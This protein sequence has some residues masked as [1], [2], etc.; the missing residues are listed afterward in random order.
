MLQNQE[1]FPSSPRIYLRI[2]RLAVDWLTP[3]AFASLRLLGC[4][5]YA[6]MTCR[7]IKSYVRHEKMRY[8]YRSKTFI[9]D[10]N[11]GSYIS[12]DAYAK[13]FRENTERI[14][15][16]RLSPHCLRHTHTAMMAEAGVSLETISR[17]LGHADSKITKE[18]YMHVTEKMKDRDREMIRNVRII[19]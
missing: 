6:S 17:R 5:L 12:Y 15:G 18:V 1:S 7:R 8:G 3:S 16:R 11:T 10:A 13:Y 19:D 14:L 2:I 9:P 4:V